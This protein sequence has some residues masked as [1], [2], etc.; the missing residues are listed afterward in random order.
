M[1][2]SAEKTEACSIMLFMHLPPCISSETK[3]EKIDYRSD[4]SAT[5]CKSRIDSDG[6]HL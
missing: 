1:G 5:R 4:S 2:S 3:V 6:S